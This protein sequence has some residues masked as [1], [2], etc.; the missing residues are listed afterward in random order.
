MTP[1]TPLDDGAG[2]QHSGSKNEFVVWLGRIQH[3]GKRNGE[4]GEISIQIR[5]KFERP[6]QAMECPLT[7]RLALAG[8]PF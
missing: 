3:F 4:R 8:V 2:A 7:N 6:M 5:E 1:R